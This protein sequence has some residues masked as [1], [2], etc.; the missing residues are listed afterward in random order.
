[1][2]RLN[3]DQFIP[4]FQVFASGTRR[5]TPLLSEYEIFFSSNAFQMELGLSLF[6]D[7]YMNIWIANVF[8][9]SSI[10]YLKR[11]SYVAM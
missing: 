7:L 4:Y 8:D 6:L 2:I 11:S 1:M 9:E 10:D 5:G 3:F